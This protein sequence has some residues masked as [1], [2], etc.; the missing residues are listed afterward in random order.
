NQEY[1]HLVKE[2][3]YGTANHDAE[4]R[5][6][7]YIYSGK[8]LAY[9]YH[10][11]SKNLKLASEFAEDIHK[12]ATEAAEDGKNP[13]WV[14]SFSGSLKAALGA[15]FIS[16]KWALQWAAEEIDLTGEAAELAIVNREHE[17]DELLASRNIDSHM[18]DLLKQYAKLVNESSRRGLELKTTMELFLASQERYFGTLGEAERVVTQ[19]VTWR[20]R[21][22]GTVSKQRYDD[23]G[24]RI[25]RND[26]LEDYH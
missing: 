3:N 21:I 19:F 12:I 4:T 2:L 14:S 13:V 6:H 22:A 18:K 24:Y 26:A 25:F 23:L 20:K 16:E 15:P 10:V 1:E 9:A 17:L 8:A 11:I 7:D 5:A